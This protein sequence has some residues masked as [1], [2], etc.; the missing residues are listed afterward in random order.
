MGLTEASDKLDS[1]IEE[2]QKE[3]E[4]AESKKEE[5]L[6]ERKRVAGEG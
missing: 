3:K 1:L 4:D 2:I 6:E 5:L